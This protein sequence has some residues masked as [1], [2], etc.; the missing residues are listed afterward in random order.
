[1]NSSNNSSN[2]NNNYNSNNNSNNNDG[3]TLTIIPAPASP[4]PWYGA[5][6]LIRHKQHE[7]FRLH[8]LRYRVR[9][10]LNTAPSL[11]LLLNG[12]ICFFQPTIQVTEPR[13]PP[14]EVVLLDS[15]VPSQADDSR[16]SST[17]TDTSAFPL[18]PVPQVGKAR[19]LPSEI[20]LPPLVVP[21]EVPPPSL[22]GAMELVKQ[23]NMLLYLTPRHPPSRLEYNPYSFK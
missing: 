2:H 4:S 8:I 10:T 14:A 22:E 16:S 18:P 11:S 6:H 21:P 13:A 12:K 23:N 9:K 19:P 1:M 17:P 3:S 5:S 7:N 15:G 20:R